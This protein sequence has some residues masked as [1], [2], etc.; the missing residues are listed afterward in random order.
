[1][2]GKMGL[3]DLFSNDTAEEAARQR[4]AGLQQGYDALSGLYGQ[5]RDALTSAY[6]KASDTYAPLVASTT[7]GANA[8]GDASGANGVAGLQR[9]MDTFKNSGQYG[10]YGFSL[11]Q[12][13]QALDRTHAAAGNLSSGNA[14][15]DAMRYATGLA[16]K[17]YSSYLSGLQPYL[18]ANNSAVSGAAGVQTGLANG[19]SQSFQG[20]GNAANANYTGQG[21]SNAAATMNEYQVGANTLNAITSAAKTAASLFGA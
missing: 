3:F 7:A 8:Y 12:G 20:Q 17:T 19:L 14:D 6:G 15:T 4:N 2:R 1:M 13:L 21:A 9:G 5:G 11:D 18:G 10:T 16:D